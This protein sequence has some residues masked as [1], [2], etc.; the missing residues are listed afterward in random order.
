LICNISF[1]G[2]HNDYS[3]A[4][5]EDFSVEGP[6]TKWNLTMTNAVKKNDEDGHTSEVC[7]PQKF[8]IFDLSIRYSLQFQHYFH[9]NRHL[10]V[11]E[12]KTLQ[13]SWGQHGACG[14]GGGGG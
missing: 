6:N 5:C 10:Q 4:F 1:L 7:P 8:C 12:E 3:K 2:F 9:T 11:E 13:F 14:M